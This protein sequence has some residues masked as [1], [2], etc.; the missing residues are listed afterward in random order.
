M[1]NLKNIAVKAQVSK[2]LW[3]HIENDISLEECVFRYGSKKYFTLMNEAKALM[4][5]GTNFDNKTKALL[6]TDLGEFGIYEGKEVALDFPM[7]NEEREDYV[8]V[9]KRNLRPLKMIYGPNQYYEKY[10]TEK[11]AQDAANDLNRAYQKTYGAAEGPHVVMYKS[12]YY[13]EKRKNTIREYIKENLRNWFKKEKWKR[14]DSQGNIAGDCG[15]MKKGKPTQR[16]LP[17]AKARSLTKKQRAAT[18]RKKVA[19]SKRGKQFV[20]NT[21]KAKVSLKKKK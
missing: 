19:G 21:P 9:D 11:G 18:A 6:E 17:L 16:C 4:N 5:E 14:I 3:Y 12:D 20:K 2:E 15:T 1:I 7:L 8:V 10:F 13:S